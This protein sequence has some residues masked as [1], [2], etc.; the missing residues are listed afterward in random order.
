MGCVI[1]FQ[2]KS[3]APPAKAKEYRNYLSRIPY[4][5][6]FVCAGYSAKDFENMKNIGMW[7]VLAGNNIII[8]SNAQFL[9]WVKEG[10]NDYLNVIQPYMEG[11]PIAALVAYVE[12]MEA[13]Q[14]K[15][16]KP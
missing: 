8:G 6:E 2:R 16:S 1:A 7:L 10:F 11:Q 13:K 14:P 15:G 5:P 9:P 3:G 4:D 12:A